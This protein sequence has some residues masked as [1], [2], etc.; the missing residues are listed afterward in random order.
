MS[1]W[2]D[3]S[4]NNLKQ[5]YLNGFLDVSGGDVKIRNNDHKLIRLRDPIL[6]I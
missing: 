5:T 2:P 4:G 1:K 3:Q 6:I